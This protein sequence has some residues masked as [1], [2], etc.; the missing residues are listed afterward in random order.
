[1]IVLGLTPDVNSQIIPFKNY[2]VRDG[3]P[4]NRIN[5]LAQDKKGF[6][7]LAT[8]SGLTRFDGYNFHTYSILDGLRDNRVECVMVDAYDAVW[9]G[10]FKGISVLRNNQFK[11]IPLP[12]GY[13]AYHVKFIFSDAE[14]N[15]WAC[16]FDEGLYK[17]VNDQAVVVNGPDGNPISAAYCYL[18]DSKGRIWI[19]NYDG[20]YRI[21]SQVK[22]IDIPELADRI[23]WDIEED[24]HGNIWVATQESGMVKLEPDTAIVYNYENNEA[25]ANFLSLG[26]DKYGNII[27]GSYYAGVHIYNSLGFSDKLISKTEDYECWKIFTDSKNR[28]W[29][30]TLDKGVL[31][32]QDG[33]L[34]NYTEENDLVSNYVLSIFE[35]SYGNVWFATEQGLSKYGKVVFEIFSEGFVK[36]DV[37]VLSVASDN[38]NNIYIGS[39][40]GLTIFKNANNTEISTISKE[41][42]HV[43]EAMIGSIYPE[44]KNNVWLGS[45]G[46]I[47]LS[48][49]KIS[50]YPDTIWTDE[51]D[52]YFPFDIIKSKDAIYMATDLGLVVFKNKKYSILST[53]NG[54]ISN[55]INCIAIDDK[56]NIWCGTSEGLS[57]YTGKKF[58]NYTVKDGLPNNKCN[59]IYY[60]SK[61]LTWLATENGLSAIVINDSFNISLK[62]FTIEDGLSSNAVYSILRASNNRLWIGHN[63]GVDCM[64]FNDKS[65][66]TYGY[67]DGF[68]PLETSPGAI[69]IDEKENIWFG[70]TEG[71]VKYNPKNDVNNYQP[72]NIIINGVSLY[73]DTSSLR[74]YYTGLS[75]ENNLPLDL[76]LP[77]NKNNL[78]FDY[79]GLH[80]TI[81]MK[82]KYR[83][84]LEGFDDKWLTVGAN[85]RRVSYSNLDPGNYLFKVL[86]GNSDGV[87]TNEA[88]EFS[89]EIL[90]PWWKT[91]WAK[92]IQVILFLIAIFL[93]VY[94]R[95]RKLRHDRDVLRIKVKERT[96][97]IE[98]QKEKIEEQKQEITDS[99]EYAQH[100]QSAILPKEESIRP[101][102]KDYFILYKPRDIVSGDFYWINGDEN[103]V[104]AIAA[105][106][107]GHGV[108]GAFLSMLGVSILNQLNATHDNMEA[109][110]ILNSLREELIRT[111]SHT[112][113]GEE[114]RDGMDMALCIIDFNSMTAQF[115]GAL[116]PLIQVRDEEPIIYKGDKMPVGYH[117]GEIKEFETKTVGL[118]KGDCLY[119]FS[120]GYADQF[121]GPNGKKFMTGKFRKLLCE[122]SPN[123]MQIQYE[124]LDK[125]IEEW[126]NGDDQIDDI[127][128]MGIRV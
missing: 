95:E 59:D 68:L 98:K 94:L 53:A 12:K 70:T 102:L 3:L 111:L 115:A 123:P 116:N 33:E 8:E 62:N 110:Q 9:V 23:V 83:Y 52:T 67:F 46:L 47:H 17:V 85:S 48:D 40:S 71:L 122:I 104:V 45:S 75:E 89:F 118:M 25:S 26:K 65:V 44:D 4:S 10:T 74:K 22:Y 84:M 5:S 100:I 56:E 109:G 29:I 61:N 78:V 58:Y 2:T 55:N 79:V 27:A 42:L 21:D 54:L 105:D 11:Q 117:A 30:T 120:D 60:D 31:L 35:D 6:L 101:I 76:K 93:F 24:S 43:E 19:G 41:D 113:K 1:M 106:C 127:L 107:T 80:F 108:P 112:N 86:A 77:F 81:V 57:I 49:K 87:W 124:I 15:V 7:W 66:K 128:V 14:N 16:N 32:L 38:S 126:K 69:A 37:G 36:D 99:I 92:V 114:A 125:T 72:P 20:L 97:E 82:N 39:Y 13:D 88:A 90:P 103:R 63:K 91:V 18:V 64:N 96:I 28:T 119:M 121:G 73:N 34:Y 51:E 50:E